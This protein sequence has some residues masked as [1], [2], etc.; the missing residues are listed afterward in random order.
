MIR[1]KR[2]TEN[3][4]V[5]PG[6]YDWRKITT[7][8][9][10]V[11]MKDGKIYLIERTGGS[12]RPF[13]CHFGLLESDDG[14]HFTHVKEEPIISPD[15]L[16]FPY[17]SIQDP[18]LVKIDELFYLTYAI[19]PCA[20]NYFPTGLGVP[21][22]SVPDYPDGWGTKKDHYIT[23][24]GIAVSEDLIN[25]KHLCYTTNTEVDDRDN[26]LF[27]EKIGGKYVLLRRPLSYVGEKYGTNAPSI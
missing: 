21:D 18:R 7:F 23:R 8:N 12:L 11:I 14:I 24:S 25:F 16:G 22:S 26:V 17:G 13:K 5:I 10:A 1:I 2:C 19:S 9:P 15:D 27:P 20:L 3:P 4:I 6:K